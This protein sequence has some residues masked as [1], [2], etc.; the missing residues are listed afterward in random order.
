MTQYSRHYFTQDFS[1]R[2]KD[3]AKLTA[4]DPASISGETTIHDYYLFT[5]RDSSILPL[6][7]HSRIIVFN[8]LYH[9][10]DPSIGS[11]SLA[12]YTEADAKNF[13]AYLHQHNQ[14]PLT[15]YRIATVFRILMEKAARE[16]LISD[17][18][19]EILWKTNPIALY[20]PEQMDK[21]LKAL[22][23]DPLENLFLVIHGAL[24]QSK[25]VRALRISDLDFKNQ[26]IH[27]SRRIRGDAFQDMEFYTVNNIYQNRTVPMTPVIAEILH[28]ELAGRERAL[29]KWPKEQQQTDLVFL[30][31]KKGRPISMI[32]IEKTCGVVQDKTGI[33]PFNPRTFLRTSANMALAHGMDARQLQY[34]MGY[35]YIASVERL[36]DP[37]MYPRI[38]ASAP[39]DNCSD[40]RVASEET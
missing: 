27:V 2:Q 20:T 34:I 1:E 26:V 12:Q 28:R 31:R 35:G 18:C 22:S 14:D 5:Y 29:H 16:G 23:G 39:A 38:A 19:S 15:R 13:L 17:S 6:D 8:Y 9:Y 33:I 11:K 37:F 10:I 25:E 4:Y 40:S 30:D 36:R 24:V 32:D 3:R 7:N 21:V